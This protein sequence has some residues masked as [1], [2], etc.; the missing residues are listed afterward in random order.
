[1]IE[2]EENQDLDKILIENI[3]KAKLN[4]GIVT[5]LRRLNALKKL[6]VVKAFYLIKESL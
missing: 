4:D 5:I 1:M 6:I 2:K 3:K